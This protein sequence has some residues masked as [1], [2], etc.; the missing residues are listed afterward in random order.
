[1]KLFT[2]LQDDKGIIKNENGDI[3]GLVVQTYKTINVE[4]VTLEK[5]DEFNGEKCEPYI[6]VKCSDKAQRVRERQII[7]LTDDDMDYLE[8]HNGEYM[9][10][11]QKSGKQFKLN[12]LPCKIMLQG[13]DL[14]ACIDYD[15]VI[16]NV[17]KI[18]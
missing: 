4:G 9:L 11:S 7:N 18:K 1:M 12:D 3:I 15:L 6:L 8:K 10:V 17:A 5:H 2:R 16:Y 14:Y 13:F